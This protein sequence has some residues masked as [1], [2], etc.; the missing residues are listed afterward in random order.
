MIR[1]GIKFD[2][3]YLIYSDSA[4]REEIRKNP[5]YSHIKSHLDNMQD[6]ITSSN[7]PYGLHRARK[8]E[9]FENEK[10]ITPSMFKVNQFAYDNQHHYVGMSFNVINKK[11]DGPSLKYLLGLLNSHFA[12]SWFYKNGK[13]RGAGVDI[14]VDKLRDFPLPSYDESKAKDIESMVT[15]I[16]ENGSNND[17]E[18]KIDNIVYQLYELSPEEIALV[19]ESVK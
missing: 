19:E 4:M 17:L 5:I 6:F 15:I 18:A 7:A 8:I 14:G 11:Q 9:N 16:L 2:N 13:H 1:Y 12:L 3:K 10:I